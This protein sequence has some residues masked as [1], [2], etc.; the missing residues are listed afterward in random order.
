MKFMFKLMASNTAQ[1]SPLI[2]LALIALMFITACASSGNSRDR[3]NTQLVS[4]NAMIH[5]QLAKGYL[6]QKQYAVAKEELEI[7]LRMDPN[8]SDANYILG[9]LMMELEQ[10]EDAEKYLRKAVR[11]DKSNSPA[12]HDLG[13]FLCQRGDLD[14]AVDYFEIAVANPFFDN[15]ELSYMR[16]G[17]CLARAGND[18]AEVYLKKAIVLNPRMRPAL[19]RMA[20][21]KHNARSYLS[22]RAYI[23]RYFAITKPQPASLLLA[24]K[25]ES[26]LKANDVAARYRL[27][28]LE[29]FPGSSEASGLRKQSRK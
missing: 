4:D 23:E 21:L 11:S 14:A 15:A 27:E 3:S 9:L 20:V 2:V 7:A 1:R 29:Q 26:K 28:L 13:T 22:A 19:Y 24:Y 10:Y 8:H 25:I 12:A 6:Q 5:A 18:K 17:E 16:A